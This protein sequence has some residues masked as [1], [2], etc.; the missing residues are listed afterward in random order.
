MMGEMYLDKNVDDKAEQYLNKAIAVGDTTGTSNA[1]NLLKRIQRR[2]KYRNEKTYNEG[3]EGKLKHLKPDQWF[4]KQRRLELIKWIDK[5]KFT[6]S[7]TSANLDRLYKKIKGRCEPWK[8]GSGFFLQTELVRILWSS[9]CFPVTD[10]E[11]N[12]EVA[13]RRIDIDMELDD[14]FCVQVWSAMRT[15]GLIT[16]GEF[17]SDTK[18][19]NLQQGLKSKLGGLGG[20]PDRDWIGLEDKLNQ[21]PDDRPGFVVVGYPIW[22]PFHRYHIEPKYCQGI[23]VNKCV[24]VLNIDL[25]AT[26]LSGHSTLY[27]HPKC[28]CV[29]TAK[30]ISK[31]MG[32]EPSTHNPLFPWP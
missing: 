5:M 12:Y 15:E 31:E 26:G 22:F 32:F 7:G 17:D 14:K 10:V 8:G 18:L 13:K 27:H 3:A 23:P 4:S 9:A 25:K 19:L 24:I 1:K 20:D 29:G 11:R 28:T 21:L 16:L 30:T 2:K 6:P